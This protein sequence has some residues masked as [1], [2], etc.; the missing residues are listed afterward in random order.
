M[1][2][3]RRQE[4]IGKVARV[5]LVDG[6]TGETIVDRNETVGNIH[7]SLIEAYLD[8]LRFN[9]YPAYERVNAGLDEYLVPADERE[10]VVLE[11]TVH[12]GRALIDL[13]DMLNVGPASLLLRN[14][15]VDRA[16][17]LQALDA[18]IA[19]FG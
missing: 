9:D 16:A 14:D 1:R 2:F 13:M 7:A 4:M 5:A 18:L 15:E 3:K 11:L 12:E 10:E 8:W 6:R 19:K 17:V